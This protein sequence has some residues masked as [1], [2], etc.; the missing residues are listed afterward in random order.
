LTGRILKAAGGSFHAETALGVV[1]CRA[2]GNLRLRDISPCAGD[3]VRLAQSGD[4]TLIEEI[5]PRKNFLPRPPTANVDLLLAVISVREPK[6]NTA[7][8]DTMTILAQLQEIEIAIAFTKCDLAEPEPWKEIYTKAG[9]KIY[10]M[11]QPKHNETDDLQA[12][13][14]EIAGKTVI[15]AGNSGAGK[16]T[17]LNRILP[18]LE[19]ETAAISRKLGRGKHTTRLTEFFRAGDMLLGDSPGFSSLELGAQGVTRQELA[20]GFRE[21]TPYAGQCRFPDC[22]HLKEP[23]CTVRSAAEDGTIPIERYRNYARFYELLT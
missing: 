19:Q 8:L 18:G 22:A 10:C 15:F 2:R 3:F 9:F 6:P 4:D 23:G 11:S 7:V 20:D 12:L 14:N 13:R 16:S 17:L 1:V 5:L 21:F